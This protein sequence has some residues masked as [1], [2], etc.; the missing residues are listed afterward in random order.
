MIVAHQSKLFRCL[1]LNVDVGVFTNIGFYP[2][3]VG[4]P[5]FTSDNSFIEL[6]GK[7]RQRRKRKLFAA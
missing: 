7:H 5:L 2:L 4:A 6:R 3:V 1:T